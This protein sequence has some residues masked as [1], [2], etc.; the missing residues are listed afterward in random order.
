MINYRVK[1]LH[2]RW[3]KIFI[4]ILIF[5]TVLATGAVVG[6]RRL[7]NENLKPLN[8]NQG[9]VTVV[10]PI[11]S[12]LREVAVILKSQKIIKS[13]WAF[14]RY[15]RNKDAS[16]EI[17]AGTY[18]LSPSLGVSEI[19]SMITEGKIATNLFTIIPG[20]RLD[21]VKKAFIVA[22]YSQQVVEN[23]LNPELY[24]DHQALVDKPANAT[25]EGYLYPD[26]YQKTASTKPETIIRQSLDEMQ[27][28]L[29]PEIRTAMAGRGYSVHQ[30]IIL[31]SIAQREADKPED[32]AQ[33]V[34]VLL[35]R[36]QKGM[37][38]ESDPT[39][40]YG[41]LLAGQAPS[42]TYDSPYN[43]YLHNGLPQGPISNVSDSSLK[44]VAY[45][46]NTDYLFFVAGDDGTVYFSKTL[47]EH[48]TKANQY[49]HKK[50]GR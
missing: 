43:T 38:L 28:H 8:S 2:K 27:K 45:P 9:S 35:T 15:V 6:V 31:A 33:V 49:C 48:Q 21:E 24:R 36:L 14:E 12:S 34:Q 47:Q 42:L 39:A 41:A 7:Y 22:G 1:K 29:T 46:A 5:V 16:D 37:K 26:S 3:T 50:C 23:A 4:I 10:I 19:V 18:E 44:A 17:K 25:L 20:K 40:F 32:R 13:S 11:G 30:G